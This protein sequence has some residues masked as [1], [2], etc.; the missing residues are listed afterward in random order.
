[1][2]STVSPLVNA[3]D[4]PDNV[5]FLV[6]SDYLCNNSECLPVAGNVQIYRDRHHL[7]SAY[8]RSLAPL[9]GTHMIR[10][11]PELNTHIDKVNNDS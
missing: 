6:L 9:L 2:L 1:M 3:S 4:V 7:S 8:V 11:A 10:I 5:R